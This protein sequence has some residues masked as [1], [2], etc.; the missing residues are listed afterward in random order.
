MSARVEFLQV[1][2]SH[3]RDPKIVVDVDGVRLTWKVRTDSVG[4]TGQ[5]APPFVGWICSVH[6]QQTWP[7][8][9]QWDPRCEHVKDA[10]SCLH[11]EVLD[12]LQHAERTR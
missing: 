6:R 7:E 9:M 3:A 2:S 10:E 11:D 5:A 12:A 1:T 8:D 4:R